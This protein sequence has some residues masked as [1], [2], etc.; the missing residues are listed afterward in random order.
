MSGKF[1][2]ASLAATTNTTVVTFTTDTSVSVNMTNRTNTPVFVRLAVSVADTPTDAEWINYDVTIP[3][4]GVLERTGLVCS[5]GEKIV[6]YASAVG[7]SVR[8]QG[9]EEIA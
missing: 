3:A 4:N 9:F 7:V 6:A 1:G 2:V 5:S 8:V